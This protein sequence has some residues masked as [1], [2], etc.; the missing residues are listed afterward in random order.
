MQK[1]ILGYPTPSGDLVGWRRKEEHRDEWCDLLV[2]TGFHTRVLALLAHWLASSLFLSDNNQNDASIFLR[3]FV[4]ET[5]DIVTM[6]A[7]CLKLAHNKRPNVARMPQGLL[8]NG[9]VVIL[10]FL[11]IFSQSPFQLIFHSN[12]SGSSHS[13]WTNERYR[14]LLPLH[15]GTFTC[16]GQSQTLWHLFSF[17]G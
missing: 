16:N 7:V 1:A 12:D 6:V 3:Y 13:S 5:V 9:L 8:Y 15:W 4:V 11:S 14:K 10:V 17:K 2:T